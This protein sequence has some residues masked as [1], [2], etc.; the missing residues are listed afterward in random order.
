MT[1]SAS[2]TVAVAA[3]KPA[4][5]CFLPK[6]PNLKKFH[7]TRVNDPAVTQ[8]PVST[9]ADTLQASE[10]HKNRRT[11]KICGGFAVREQ[12]NQGRQRGEKQGRAHFR[13]IAKRQYSAQSL[14]DWR[15][16]IGRKKASKEV[17]PADVRRG[18]DPSSPDGLRRGRGPGC[19]VNAALRVHP[20]ISAGAS[21]RRT[22]RDAE[23]GSNGQQRAG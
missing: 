19:R 11:G 18:R 16:G 10:K 12:N 5:A 3:T 23:A 8:H 20:G 17:P 14:G 7:G 1:P 2:S 6:S 9:R 21:A 13:N 4:A 22:G 15:A